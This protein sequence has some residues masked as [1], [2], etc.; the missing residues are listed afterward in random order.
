MALPSIQVGVKLH[1]HPRPRDLIREVKNCP[2]LG[3]PIGHEIISAKRCCGQLRSPKL[4]R[5][6]A[7]TRITSATAT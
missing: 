4:S 2:N 6:A 5:R 7:R 1:P 3:F